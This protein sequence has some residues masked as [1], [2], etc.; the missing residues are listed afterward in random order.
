MQAEQIIEYFFRLLYALF[1]G[2]AGV[3]LATFYDFIGRVWFWITIV[4]Y[5][6]SVLGFGLIIYLTM[7]LFELRRREREY[8]ETPLTTKD[9][10]KQK[11]PRWEHINQLMASDNASAWREA[12]TEADILLEDALESR[13][14]E[15]DGVG[16]KL[17]RLDQ[18]DLGSLEDAWEAHKVRN[19]IAHQGSA[20]ALSEALAHRTIQ[21]YE[22]V[23]RELNA[24]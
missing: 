2:S 12:I 8:Y 1:F 10:A 24:I 21:R 23:F 22:H 4:G 9:Q 3:D 15:G 17:K 13:S 11:N 5:G 14:Y 6:V 20:Y 7:Q 18:A 19:A 16:E